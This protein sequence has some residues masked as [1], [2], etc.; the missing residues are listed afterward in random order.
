MNNSRIITVYIMVIVGLLA[1]YFIF[2][3]IFFPNYFLSQSEKSKPKPMP[4]ITYVYTSE[5]RI[6]KGESFKISLA[7]TNKG[8]NADVQ[9]VSVSFPN[10][11]SLISRASIDNKSNNTLATILR[12]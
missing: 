8:D 4:I 9:T 5:S 12:Q 7:A 11:T 2:S 3:F 1:T 6:D 10:S